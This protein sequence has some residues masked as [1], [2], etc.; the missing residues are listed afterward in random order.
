MTLRTLQDCVAARSAWERREGGAAAFDWQL[1]FLDSNLG[2]AVPGS[3][4][5]VGARTGTGKSYFTLM[6]LSSLPV[7]GL[8]VSVE[9]S[10]VELGRRARSLPGDAL[11]RVLVATPHA[12]LSAVLE[13][14][15]VG[16]EAGAR[17]AVVDYLQEL[18]AD[19]GEP[20]FGRADEVR[21]MCTAMKAKARDLG[22]VL[23]LVSQCKRPEAGRAEEM[24][25]RYELS[26]CSAIEKKAEAIIMLL[27][28]GP[29]SM[30]ARIDKYKS[31]RS[32]GEAEFARGR[33]GLLAQVDQTVA[34]AA[35]DLFG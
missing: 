1:P 32:G 4:Y 35:E 10:A 3:M 14:I 21:V 2:A 16:A 12:R 9:D 26:D 23:V 13:A 19:T 8:M 5:V 6:L 34:V 29:S 11:S 27:E 15:D 7:P 18:S 17:V 24:P 25:T 31:G 33:D 28:T 20:M 22:L 30:R